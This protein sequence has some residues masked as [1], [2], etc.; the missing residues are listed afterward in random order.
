MSA[1]PST[2]SPLSVTVKVLVTSK[3]LERERFVTV[4]SLVVSPS[5]S[6][7][8]SE[9]S[10]TLLLCPGLL[11]VANAVFETLPV[12]AVFTVTKYDEEKVAISPTV[13]VP[14]EEPALLETK[15]GPL[16]KDKLLL[17][18]SLIVSFNANPLKVTLPLF[19]TVIE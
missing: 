3:A 2:P 5:L 11:A 4:S 16:V 19:K 12:F 7:P 8:S 6:S 9:V 15:V 18:P 14:W 10:V 1:A 13:N 17:L